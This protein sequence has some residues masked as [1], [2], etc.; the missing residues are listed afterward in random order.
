LY[1]HESSCPF[2]YSHQ[3]YNFPLNIPLLDR[4]QSLL[5]HRGSMQARFAAATSNKPRVE[6]EK[7]EEGQDAMEEEEK[8]EEEKDGSSMNTEKKDTGRIEVAL[9][10]R[11]KRRADDDDSESNIQKGTFAGRQTNTESPAETLAKEMDSV[12]DPLVMAKEHVARS[13]EVDISS[14][15]KYNHR[16]SQ[17]MIRMLDFW[18]SRRS[19]TL[20]DARAF[21]DQDLFAV[22]LSMMISLNG[23]GHVFHNLLHI[24]LGCFLYIY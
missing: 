1:S 8:E 9:P 3:F 7:S 20:N 19:S 21:L 15:K 6:S 22:A 11:R 14:L 10:S 5:T 16:N 23:N 24:I 12:E 13:P 4:R 17:I 18:M 2:L